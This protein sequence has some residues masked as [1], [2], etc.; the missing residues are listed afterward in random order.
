MNFSFLRAASRA[1]P[2]PRA[3]R[4]PPFDYLALVDAFSREKRTIRSPMHNR[5]PTSFFSGPPEKTFSLPPPPP[6]VENDGHFFFDVT[7]K[8]R[9]LFPPPSF[10]SAILL[11]AAVDTCR[12]VSS[13]MKMRFELPP[14]VEILNFFFPPPDL[15]LPLQEHSRRTELLLLATDLIAD[16]PFFFS[17]SL[18]EGPGASPRSP[19]LF[20]LSL[21]YYPVLLLRE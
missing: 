10:S 1:F 13:L 4:F 15:P 5:D 14:T 6:V 9:D 8:K 17:P 18:G 7:V 11:T 21:V 3:A 19:L 16:N 20:F 2:L 12:H